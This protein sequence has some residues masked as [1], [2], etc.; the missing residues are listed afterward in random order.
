M[1]YESIINPFLTPLSTYEYNERTR[2]IK[3]WLEDHHETNVLADYEQEAI[4]QLRDNPN[5]L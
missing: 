5:S 3:G 1:S 4:K 2:E